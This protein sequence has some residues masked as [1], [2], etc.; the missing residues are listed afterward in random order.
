MWD[1]TICVHCKRTLRTLKGGRVVH[2]W[3]L[4]EAC[5]LGRNTSAES[6]DEG[7]SSSV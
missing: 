7:H 2:D 5:G 4:D 3:S 1:M 6:V